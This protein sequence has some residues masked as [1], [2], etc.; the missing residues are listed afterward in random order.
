M[1]T[2]FVYHMTK[3]SSQQ[4]LYAG[5]SVFV[6][7]II[8]MLKSSDAFMHRPFSFKQRFSTYRTVGSNVSSDTQVRPPSSRADSPS[9]TIEG[10]GSWEELHGNY[11]LRPSSDYPD[12]Q[13]RA[14]IHFLGGAL[15]GAAPDL[16]YRYMLEKLAQRGFLIV[17]TP[18]T[19]SFDYIKLCDDIIR[20]FENIAPMLASQYGALPVV[21]V[22]HSCGALLHVCKPL[23]LKYIV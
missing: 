23:L 16:S 19:L 5:L 14:L 18:Y 7:S 15:V 13:P 21:G 22:G 6:W 4:Q 3:T 9:S 11:V 8:V 10:L 12:Q 2:G 17:A 20:R 1:R